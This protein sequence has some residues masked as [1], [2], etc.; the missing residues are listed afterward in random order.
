M[1]LDDVPSLK[2]ELKAAT[3]LIPILRRV[4]EFKSLLQKQEKA[5]DIILKKND[6][7]VRMPTGGG[8]SLLYILPTIARVVLTLV[9]F[10]TLS[11]VKH[12]ANKLTSKK[13]KTAVFTGA[14]DADTK[15]NILLTLRDQDP[16]LKFFFILP[17]MVSGTR[18][19]TSLNQVCNTGRLQT[20]VFDEAHFVATWGK[21]FRPSYLNCNIFKT[22]FSECLILL[23]SVSATPKKFK[24][25]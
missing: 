24:T 16:D 19:L 14:T 4:F 23:L 18:L 7:L 3:D 5:I 12:Q 10:P 6:C 11:L 21:S 2:K 1:L 9:T 13:V 22:Q 25:S 15:D 8:K 20:I 17:E